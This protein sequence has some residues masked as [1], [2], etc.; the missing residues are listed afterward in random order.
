LTILSLSLA[1]LGTTHENMGMTIVDVFNCRDGFEESIDRCAPVLYEL[2]YKL[3]NIY[4][5]KID[6][7]RTKFTFC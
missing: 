4:I 5:Y 2:L 6:D 7:M 3:I 1:R